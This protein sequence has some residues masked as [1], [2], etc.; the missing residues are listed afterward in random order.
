MSDVILWPRLPYRST[1]SGGCRR[2]AM[3]TSKLRRTRSGS[4][5]VR[6]DR[7]SMTSKRPDSM[8]WKPF[9]TLSPSCDRTLYPR[10]APAGRDVE[11]MIRNVSPSYS[12][13]AS[14]L[15]ISGVTF[16]VRNNATTAATV[17]RAVMTNMF[18]A[19]RTRRRPGDSSRSFRGDFML[20]TTV[21][22]LSLPCV[23]TAP[24][25]PTHD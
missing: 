15:T 2:S 7:W 5:P 1:I 4:P 22:K 16:S 18:R 6:S 9:V 24:E 3:T 11:P 21:S 8:T 12:A 13:A 25:D 10:I 17:N 23:A 14:T 19:C 20:H